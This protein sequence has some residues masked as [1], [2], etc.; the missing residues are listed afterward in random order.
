M[1]IR[2][3]GL[4]RRRVQAQ[5]IEVETDGGSLLDLLARAEELAGQRF[6]DELLDRDTGLLAGT[7]ILVNGENVRLLRGLD[8]GVR[9][10]DV[11]DLFSPAGGG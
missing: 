5:V 1:T 7:M 2:F 4:L 8:T 9:A 11:V 6:L 10:G 3:Y